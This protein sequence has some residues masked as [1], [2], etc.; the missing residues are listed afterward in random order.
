MTKNY[1]YIITIKVDKETKEKV[2]RKAQLDG[3]SMSGHIRWLIERDLE[4][5][6]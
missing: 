2:S 1:N 3:R 4:D 5:R 6:K